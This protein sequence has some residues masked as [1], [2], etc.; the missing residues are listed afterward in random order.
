MTDKYHTPKN[1]P[2]CDHENNFVNPDINV[3]T[4]THIL[5]CSWCGKTCGCGR[6]K[7]KIGKKGKGNLKPRCL[8]SNLDDN[9]N[10]PIITY[11]YKKMQE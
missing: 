8:F 7:R 11:K 10:T 4:K 6:S 2:C 3:S 9:E 1:G 5:C